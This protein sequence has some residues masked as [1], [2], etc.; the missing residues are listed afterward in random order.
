M[1]FRCLRNNH[2]GIDCR[3][4]KTCGI[5][6]CEKIHRP[7]LHK[8][9]AKEQQQSA[10]N[11]EAP[12][13]TSETTAHSSSYRSE[14]VTLRTVPVILK[15][16]NRS[17]KVNALLDDGSTRTY[18]NANVAAEL[19]IQGELRMT[20]NVLNNNAETFDTMSVQLGI[21]STD[22]R[23]KKTTETQ[24]VKNVTGSLKVVNWEIEATK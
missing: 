13:F 22:G 21:K 12:S 9:I 20:V 5:N 6:G 24:T 7:L 17:L 15:S 10:L 4:V 23:L 8:P 2:L 11:P 14:I 19:G 18:V 16:G 1:C 3:N